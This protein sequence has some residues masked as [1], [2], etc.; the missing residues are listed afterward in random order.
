MTDLNDYH[1]LKVSKIF[2]EL[3]KKQSRILLLFSLGMSY[4]KCAKT[5]SCSSSYIDNNLQE[6]KEELNLD[7]VS[8]LRVVFFI[9][10]VA[11]RW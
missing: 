1:F 8:D 7:S 5:L 4:K 3:T 2:P 11:N 10:V 9:R 6:I